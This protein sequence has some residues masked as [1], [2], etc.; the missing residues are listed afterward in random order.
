MEESFL[1]NDD[2]FDNISFTFQSNN[3]LR[4]T[5][6]NF[7]FTENFIEYIKG[8]KTLY[9]G[10]NISDH[11]PIVLNISL[12]NSLKYINDRSIKHNVNVF[13]W[14]SAIENDINNYRAILDE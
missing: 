13:N 12:D 11:F 1:S 8:F 10:N 3:G 6:D 2:I 4:S 14:K 9:D 7:I 5:I